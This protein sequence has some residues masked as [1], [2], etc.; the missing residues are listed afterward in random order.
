MRSSSKIATFVPCPRRP[1]LLIFLIHHSRQFP[2]TISTALI[3]ALFIIHIQDAWKDNLLTATSIHPSTVALPTNVVFY[4]MKRMV[5]LAHLG[6]IATATSWLYGVIT[7]RG[8]PLRD[9][10]ARSILIGIKVAFA[11]AEAIP[12]DAG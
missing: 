3:C 4:V 5:T 8:H 7:L 1:L 6:L 9:M 2:P 10:A 12:L 11:S